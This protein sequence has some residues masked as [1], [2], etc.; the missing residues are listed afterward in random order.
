MNAL[1]SSKMMRPILYGNPI[2]S[3]VSGLLLIFAARP[4]ASFIGIDV[5]LAILQLGIGLAG[6]AAL[7]YLNATRP[8]IARS[9]VLTAVICDSLW[10]VLSIMLLTTD[11]V[12]FSVAGTWAVGIIA[13][14]V[15]VFATLQFFEWRKM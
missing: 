11:W 7:L 12:S 15:A 3:S 2:F 9:F 8:E 5:P 10:V 1:G 14:I 6:Y 13:A 4:I